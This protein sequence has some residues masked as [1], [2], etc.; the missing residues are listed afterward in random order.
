MRLFEQYYYQTLIQFEKYN[1]L[2]RNQLS[3]EADSHTLNLTLGELVSNDYLNQSDNIFEI[4]ESGKNYLKQNDKNQDNKKL[5]ILILEHLNNNQ[6]YVQKIDVVTPFLHEASSEQQRLEL[7]RTLR[8]LNSENCIKLNEDAMY[9]FGGRTGGRLC[10]VNQIGVKASIT[11]K[12]RKLIEP[13]EEKS[14][15]S[16]TYNMHGAI[17]PIIGDNNQSSTIAERIITNP[18][19]INTTPKKNSIA[20]KVWLGILIAVIGGFI[21]FLVERLFS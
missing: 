11:E 9:N 3:L 7:L 1:S 13:K 4:T 19:T 15:V 12:G 17:N 5:W 10:N 18:T 14:I 16:H 8:D 20:K 6:A 2:N 21:L